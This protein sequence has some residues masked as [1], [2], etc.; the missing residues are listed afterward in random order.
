MWFE[1]RGIRITVAV[2]TAGV[3][4]HVVQDRCMRVRQRRF[5][6]AA[7]LQEVIESGL[8]SERTDSIHTSVESDRTV[9]SCRRN[10]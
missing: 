8:L 2:E 10:D 1:A 6:I 5:R 4:L 9:H 7:R 3:V